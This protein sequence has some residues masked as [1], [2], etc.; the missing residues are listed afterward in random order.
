M[1]LR[2]SRTCDR[3]LTWA[4]A[5]AAGLLLSLNHVLANWPSWRGPTANGSI[6]AGAYPTAW[7]LESVTWKFPLPGKGGSTPIISNHRIYLTTPDAGQDVE[8]ALDTHGKKL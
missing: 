6:S 7:S 1:H 3:A 2:L 4:L 5:S 8:L